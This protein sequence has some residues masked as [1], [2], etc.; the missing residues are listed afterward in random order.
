VQPLKVTVNKDDPNARGYVWEEVQPMG[1]EFEQ[2]SVTDDISE[3]GCEDSVTNDESVNFEET[4]A[5]EENS[6]CGVIVATGATDSVDAAG[7]SAGEEAIALLNIVAYAKK[8]SSMDAASLI[9]T[10][11]VASGA[12]IAGETNTNICEAPAKRRASLNSGLVE[13]N[14]VGAIEET[15]LPTFADTAGSGTEDEDVNERDRKNRDDLVKQTIQLHTIV[16]IAQQRESQ[17]ESVQDSIA[18]REN[19]RGSVQCSIVQQREN[20]ELEILSSISAI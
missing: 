16:S 9:A 20:S 11:T 10:Q 14:S 3:E 1:E 4:S 8:R 2:A 5:I 12:S 6:T 19:S 7:S 18:Q 13:E 15:I 17:N